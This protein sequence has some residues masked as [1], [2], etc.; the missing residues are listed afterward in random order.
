VACYARW[1]YHGR[2]RGGAPKPGETPRKPPAKPDRFIPARCRHGHVLN[3]KNLR[4]RPDG[5]RY[6][7][8][9]RYVTEKTYHERQFTYRHDGHDV[10]PT[11]D[12][13]RYCRT[14][15]TGAHD[16][17]EIAVERAAGGEPPARLSRA[18]REAAVIELR[19][20]GYPY[21]LIAA[22]VG[23]SLRT[24]WNICRRNGLTTPRMAAS[25]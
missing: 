20:Y 12:G 18:E 23:C 15:N 24:A 22:R 1:V 13:R 10:I 3:A 8:A 25:P 17:D 19:G 4:F 2:P 14:C 7:R 16:V 6:C 9:C 11:V 5:V 21:W